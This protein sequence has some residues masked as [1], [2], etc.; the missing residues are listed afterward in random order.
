MCV[1]VSYTLVIVAAGGAGLG[2][3]V[4]WFRTLSVSGVSIRRDGIVAFR[5][6]RRQ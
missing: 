1:W 5:C 3:F 2:E 4:L 6:H